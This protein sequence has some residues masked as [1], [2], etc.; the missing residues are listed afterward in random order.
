M[1]TYG[2]I[3]QINISQWTLTPSVP[4]PEQELSIQ[5]DDNFLRDLGESIIAD[6][7]DLGFS[8][9]NIPIKSVG[10]TIKKDWII[11]K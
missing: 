3:S 2:N 8:K 1:K 5:E 9:R 11:D 4:K 7:A 6:L 10:V